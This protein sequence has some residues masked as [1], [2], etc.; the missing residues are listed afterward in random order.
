MTTLLY[1]SETWTVYSK[2][3]RKL[4]HFHKICLRRI[5]GIKWQDR[6]PD[7]E[8]L[9]KAG[10]PS[11][12]TILMQTQLR[13]AGHVSRMPDHR[14]PKQILFGE[15]TEG[16]RSAGGPKKRYKDTLKSSLKAF[17]LNNTTLEKAAGDRKTWRKTIHK[18]AKQHETQRLTT[19][20]LRRQARKETT[21]K[22]GTIPCPHC[23]RLF[24]ARIGISS[25]LRTH[26]PT[27]E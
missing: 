22:E 8:L 1:G 3:A 27:P 6:V 13:W 12:I 18:W 10:L 21:P 9:E 24:R 15:L 4:N 7:T 20:K 26:R 14:L 23:P 2:H 25:H 16:K 11:I 5:L 17:V 19:A